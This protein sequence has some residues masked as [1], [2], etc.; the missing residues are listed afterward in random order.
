MAGQVDGGDGG[1]QAKRTAQF[2][3]ALLMTAD[4]AVPLTAKLDTPPRQF[5][6]KVES[7]ERRHTH[8]MSSEQRVGRHDERLDRCRFGL[9]AVPVGRFFDGATLSQAGALT[10]GR[11]PYGGPSQA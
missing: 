9:G 5:W 7:P 6:E 3:H 4:G 8:E 1:R 2:E 11:A 10:L